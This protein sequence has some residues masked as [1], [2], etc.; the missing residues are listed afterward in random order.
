MF[1]Y[2]KTN[3]VLYGILFSVCVFAQNKTDSLG[4]KQGYWKVY[5]PN[6]KHLEYEGLYKDNQP[7][8]LFKYY[9]EH[10]TIKAKLDFKKGG[11]IAYAILYHWNGK[12]MA[13]GK[14]LEQKKDSVWEFFNEAGLLV[15]RENYLQG[16]RHGLS[17]TY[18]DSGKVYQKMQYI[19]NKK[20]GY[21]IEY[22]PDGKIKGMGYYKEDLP[23]GHFVYYAPNGT[24]VGLITYK[25]GIRHGPV[26]Y[27][28]MD[29]KIKEKV[30]MKN[31]KEANESESNEYFQKHPEVLNNEFG[32]DK[33]VIKLFEKRN[34]KTFTQDNINPENK[35]KL[36]QSLPQNKSSSHSKSTSKSKKTK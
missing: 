7:Q 32:L 2:Q 27:K 20:H 13:K 19:L 15:N 1:R 21:F 10:D 22:F 24:R 9:Y 23:D 29:G 4:R 35:E 25:D 30:L 17:I 36:L 14:Y 26:V 11:K 3:I 16:Q 12:M 31:G 18:Y 8:G 6:S 5:Y 28:E 33:D 34:E